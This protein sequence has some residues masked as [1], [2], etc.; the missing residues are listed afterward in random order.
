[1]K[2]EYSAGIIVYHETDGVRKYL[3]LCYHP[4]YWG[5]PKG[6]VE[7][8]ETKLQ[9]AHREL[10]EETGLQAQVHPNFEES[11]FYIFKDK[12]RQLIRK[13][14]TFFVGRA[15]STDVILSFEHQDFK[16]LALHDAVIH[17]TYE[18]DREAVSKADQFLEHLSA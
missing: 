12:S 18:K 14:V 3:I 7:D 4:Q 1:M 8:G 10:K 17:L 15:L 5:L 2:Q 11:H 13:E 6:R 16:W 9:A